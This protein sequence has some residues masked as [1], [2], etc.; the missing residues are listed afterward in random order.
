M[1][2]STKLDVV[3]AVALGEASGVLELRV[4]EV[5]ADGR[6]RSVD[7]ARRKGVGARAGTQIEHAVARPQVGEVEVIPT[8]ANEASAAYGKGASSDSG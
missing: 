3:D 7:Q 4:G 6:G 8:P 5:D 1:L 2:A